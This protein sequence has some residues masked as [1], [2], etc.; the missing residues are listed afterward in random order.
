[1]R[2]ALTIVFTAIIGG[3]AVALG[4]F[5]ERRTIRKRFEPVISSPRARVIRRRLAR[6]GAV[7]L[8]GSLTRHRR[9]YVGDQPQCSGG[10]SERACRDA[11]CTDAG[12]GAPGSQ[13]E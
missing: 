1:M 12:H 2:L 4:L 3:S 9:D 5:I 6:L 13:G 7:Y 11:A 8:V 10:T